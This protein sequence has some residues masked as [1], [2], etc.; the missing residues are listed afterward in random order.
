MIYLCV[1]ITWYVP[2]IWWT[3][4]VKSLFRNISTEKNVI[5]RRQQVGNIS[6]FFPCRSAVSCSSSYPLSTGQTIKPIFSS[7]YHFY[8]TSVWTMPSSV[9]PHVKSRC[10]QYPGSDIKRFPVPDD[11]VDWSHKWPQYKPISYTHPSVSKKPAWADPEL[12]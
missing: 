9:A 7:C 5:K 6:H 2:D 12:G 11:K 4:H 10:P 3:S 1:W 8:T